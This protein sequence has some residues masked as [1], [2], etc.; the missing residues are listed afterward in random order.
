MEGPSFAGFFNSIPTAKKAMSNPIAPT[1]DEDFAKEARKE[2]LPLD[3]YSKAR[4]G[5]H[6]PVHS[7]AERSKHCAMGVCV[8]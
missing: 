2:L 7:S 5:T 6:S 4:M 1:M 3:E 8:K